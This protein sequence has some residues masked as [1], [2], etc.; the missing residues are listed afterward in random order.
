[1]F[2]LY[3]ELDGIAAG[4]IPEIPD[5][6]LASLNTHDMPPFA[7][8]W[9]GL[10]ISQHV[11]AGIVKA[12][13]APS[14]RRI[15]RR[16]TKSLLGILRSVCPDIGDAQDLDVVLRCTLGWLGASR[17]RY[18]MVNLEDLWHETAQQNIPGVGAAH[19]S[20]RRRIACTLEE[21]WRSPSMGRTLEVLRHAINPSGTRR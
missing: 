10:D 11:R 5:N 4:R 3:Y 16:A 14:A 17:A 1:M 15:R 18:V 2:V 9:Q 8:M 13:Q 7:A 20:W 21:I 6:C 12:E 19:P